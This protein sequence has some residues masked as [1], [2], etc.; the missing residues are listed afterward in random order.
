MPMHDSSIEPSTSTANAVNTAIWPR[1]G[2]TAG[3]WPVPVRCHR[4]DVVKPLGLHHNDPSDEDA[5]ET[6]R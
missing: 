5:D 1:T 3:V 2:S 6:N 4:P